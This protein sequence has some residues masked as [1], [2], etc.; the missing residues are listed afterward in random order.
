M[1]NISNVQRF[2]FKKF[3]DATKQQGLSFQ[4]PAAGMIEHSSWPWRLLIRSIIVI[5]VNSSC[6]PIKSNQS[7]GQTQSTV[8]SLLFCSSVFLDRGWHEG[9]AFP[10]PQILIICFPWPSVCFV[11][12]MHACMNVPSGFVAGA[13]LRLRTIVHQTLTWL[14][15]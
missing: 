8:N 3:T 10:W 4:L 6:N 2:Y 14:Y 7:V 15:I 13:G 9:Q 12:V 11:S 1:F 5:P